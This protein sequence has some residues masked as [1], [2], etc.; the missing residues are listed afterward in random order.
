M[1]DTAVPIGSRG[2]SSTRSALEVGSWCGHVECT[3]E[4]GLDWFV[5]GVANP[6]GPGRGSQ[7]VDLGRN[8][9]ASASQNHERGLLF[10]FSRWS[11][12]SGLAGRT[13]WFDSRISTR[14]D[15]SDWHVVAS[16]PGATAFRVSSRWFHGPHGPCVSRFGDHRGIVC[17]FGDRDCAGSVDLATEQF[18]MEHKTPFDHPWRPGKHTPEIFHAV[19]SIVQ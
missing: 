16:D 18:S 5:D 7:L 10:L 12:R 14:H 3:I 1:Q 11:R 13:R 6:V 15:R 8:H 19:F 2:R 9:A 4:H 17:P